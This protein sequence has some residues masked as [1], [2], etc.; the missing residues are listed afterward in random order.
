MYIYICLS[1]YKFT[2]R[3]YCQHITEIQRGED[4]TMDPEKKRS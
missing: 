3:R 4:G 2:S 1:I